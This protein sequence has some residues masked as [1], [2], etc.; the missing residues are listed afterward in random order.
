[1]V[2]VLAGAAA[3][4]FFAFLAITLGLFAVGQL[5]ATSYNASYFGEENPKIKKINELELLVIEQLEMDFY[6]NYALKND[7]RDLGTKGHFND[8][9]LYTN[10]Q[11]ILGIDEFLKKNQDLTNKLQGVNDKVVGQK[12]IVNE[13]IKENLKDL[14]EYI[15][16]HKDFVKKFDE[17]A[18]T[19]DGKELQ[20][21]RENLD[22]SSLIALAKA[23]RDNCKANISTVSLSGNMED[24][25]TPNAPNTP[26][27]VKEN[28]KD[29]QNQ[30]RA[31]AVNIF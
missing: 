28:G 25:Y 20:L 21:D 10:S 9:D 15:K 5:F 31:D 2:R 27:N 26:N 14:F 23:I 17:R 16:Q 7:I 8:R 13:N 6:K 18:L 29:K 11:I 12:I 24:I 4:Q 19:N 30:K 3:P 1:M 22:P